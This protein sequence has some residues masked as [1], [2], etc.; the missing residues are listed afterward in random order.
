MQM[1][2]LGISSF[3]YRLKNDETVRTAFESRSDAAF[4]GFEL[5]QDE[6]T[7]LRDGDVVALYR[8]GVHPLLLA[9]FSRYAGIPRPKYQAALA[10]LKGLRQLR[11]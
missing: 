6:K 5:T 3:I 8:L 2:L 9:P 4:E 1:S 11:S 10:P 7:A